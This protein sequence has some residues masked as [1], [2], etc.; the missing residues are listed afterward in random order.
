MSNVKT[1]QP[2]LE[3]R[4]NLL[5]IKEHT[6]F[7][8]TYNLIRHEKQLDIVW[9]K[10]PDPQQMSA[11]LLHKLT[12][13]K[14]HWVQNFENPPIAGTWSQ[15]LISQADRIIVTTRRDYNKL[16]RYGIRISKIRIEN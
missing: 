1:Q 5:Q 10:K 8:Q 12:G 13:R 15:I 3:L 14:F 7:G 2:P 4:P 16:R 9:V 11:V 6:T